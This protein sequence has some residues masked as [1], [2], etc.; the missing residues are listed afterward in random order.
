MTKE[1]KDIQ[2]N[3]FRRRSLL[4]LAGVASIGGGFMA[5]APVESPVSPVGR[6]TAATETVVES[7]ENTELSTD[8]S[9]DRGASGASLVSSPSY[10]G[11]TALAI[12]DTNTE[13]I[14]TGQFGSDTPA[15][16]E[17]FRYRFQVT[18]AA[19]AGWN[20]TYGVQDHDNR[21]YV[22]FDYADS[23]F[24]L[25]K[26]LNT[27]G[28][29][30]D[31]TAFTP[32]EEEW[33]TVE[34]DWATD[35][36]HT[37][38]LFDSSDTQVAQLSGTDS[39][40]TS[41]EIGFD[42]Y[43][44]DS[45]ATVTFDHVTLVESGSGGGG[46]S[47][48]IVFDDFEDGSLSEYNFDRGAS[49]ASVVTDPDPV[50]EGDYA[51]RLKETNTEMISTSGLDAYPQAGDTIRFYV[52]A[53]DT[54]AN[55]NFSYGV[56]DHENR[57]YLSG[58]LA[59]GELYF[60]IYQN[61][62]SNSLGGPSN[63]P[64]EANVW[65]EIE[66]TWG[67]DG[68]HFARLLHPTDGEIAT[69]SATESTWT[70]G[71]IG[72]DAYLSSGQSVYFDYVRNDVVGS[73]TDRVVDSFE[74]GDLTEWDSEFDQK[75][76]AN[77]VSGPVHHG[78]QAL[79]LSGEHFHLNSTSGLDNYPQAGD[80][81]SGW[82]RAGPNVSGALVI[83]YGVQD[84]D[85]HYVARINYPYDNVIIRKTENGN[86]T[87]LAETEMGFT[88][89]AWYEVE[90]DWGLD[91]THT[92]TMYDSS[93]SQ[94]GSVSATDST[95]TTGGI[96]CHAHLQ[97]GGTAQFDYLAI[98]QTRSLGNF[99]DD[100]KGW[101]TNGSNSL[102]S[103]SGSQ[104]PASVTR[105]DTALEVTVNSDP[106]PVIENQLQTQQADL[107]TYPCLLADVLPSNVQNTDSP[108]TFRF[109]YHHSDPGGVEESPEMTVDQRYGRRICWD[110][111]G[112]ST[113]KLES[114]ERLDI[115]WYPTNHPPGSGFDHNGTVC[116]D[117]VQITDDHNQVTQARKM[118]LHQ[119]HVRAHGPMIDQIT[120]SETSTAQDGVYEHYD[121]T[122]VSYRLEMLSNGNIKETCDGK[123][124]T[125]EV[126]D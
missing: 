96:G 102:G 3:S 104:Q 27:D 59:D 13:L 43:L 41:G 86:H 92:V 2:T 116:V 65:Y 40:W 88:A 55:F 56:Q 89:D 110:M 49:G 21:Y 6:A 32:T 73:P 97:N 36:T 67:T 70:S 109:R 8:Y 79:E 66:L 60:F 75:N 51:L 108:L 28:N 93:G 121:G 22:Q 115:V 63:V 54:T 44:A 37:V 113:T 124:F 117:N 57:Y 83:T 120:Q 114:P 126:S 68:T 30:I 18:N 9:F 16:G 14:S 99:E 31:S 33:Y 48:G 74:D 58:D 35:G 78:S 4:K 38:T 24:R 64:Y 85:N 118:D 34:I 46:S 119:E 106:E 123:T 91:G 11:T 19:S 100:L 122:Q 23:K 17:T 95:F 1:V 94:L 20:F 50:R 107:T 29:R 98:S 61:D 90:I 12:S 7:F 25:Y 101:E 45:S 5:G 26:Y 125:L 71:G 82:I 87:T 76:L 77:V 42:A 105:N 10:S 84:F 111:S 62:D 69:A 112:L 72:F 53:N 52:R 47:D 80:T 81:F 39:E 15:A 103:V